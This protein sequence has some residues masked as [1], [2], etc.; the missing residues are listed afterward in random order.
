MRKR[1]LKKLRKKIFIK[2]YKL[3]EML[4]Q[5]KSKKRIEKWL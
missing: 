5:E 3:I 4:L 2:F 1:K